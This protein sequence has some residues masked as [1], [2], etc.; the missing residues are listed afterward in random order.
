MSKEVPHI[1]VPA[2]IQKKLYAYINYVILISKKV[3]DNYWAA[4]I[5]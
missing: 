4:T 3:P 1:F 2:T 5:H